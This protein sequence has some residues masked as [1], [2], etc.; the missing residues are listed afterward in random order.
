[1]PETK[2]GKKILSHMVRQYG[3]ERKGKE[4]FY[5]SIN[6]G[7]IHGTGTQTE[8]RKRKHTR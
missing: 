6:K 3:S 8:R 4:V 2:K 1:M 5:A 7:T